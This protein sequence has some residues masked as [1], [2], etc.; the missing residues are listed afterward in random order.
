MNIKTVVLKATYLFCLVASSVAFASQAEDEHIPV[1]QRIE[2]HLERV[3]LK[4]KR[5][6]APQEKQETEEK[7]GNEALAGAET[8]QVTF[9]NSASDTRFEGAKLPKSVAY[10][11]THQGI[12][13]TP[14][15]VTYSGDFVY[16]DDGS[17][18]SVCSYDRYKTLNWL[19]SDSI[20]IMPNS[21]VYSIYDFCLVNLNTGAMV[22][23]NMYLGPLYAGV[24]TYWITGIDYVNDIVYLND[25]SSW[26]ISVFDSS[27]MSKWLLNDTVILGVNNDSSSIRPNI[28]IN[29]NVLNYARAT[30]LN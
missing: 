14:T 13:R 29:V 30:C 11:T 18:W 7:L 26:G 24:N 25:N 19:T 15:S 3:S 21:N 2:S 8:A 6:E 5:L 28:L 4:E 17:S 20:V 16:L 1:G 12:Y 10:Y 27:T 22:Q 9:V 23:V